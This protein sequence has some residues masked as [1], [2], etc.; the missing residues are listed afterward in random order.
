MSR[1]LL[2]SSLAFPLLMHG[3]S[4]NPPIR[5]TGVPTDDG[6]TVCTAC[7]RT[8]GVPNPDTQGS[9]TVE[10]SDVYLPGVPQPVKVTVQHPL[11]VRWGFELTAGVV[12]NTNDQAGSFLG[13]PDTVTNCDG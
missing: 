2:L 11:A 3:F 7:H 1:L 8:F 4:H 6:G 9:V 10:T 13:G 12:N 5:R